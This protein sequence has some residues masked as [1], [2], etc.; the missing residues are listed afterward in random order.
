MESYDGAGHMKYFEYSSNG[1][2]KYTVSGTGTYILLSAATAAAILHHRRYRLRTRHRQLA[3]PCRQPLRQSNR[4]RQ[5]H[6][7]VRRQDQLE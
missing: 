2:A 5:R 1:T 4:E 7:F 6:I 3:G